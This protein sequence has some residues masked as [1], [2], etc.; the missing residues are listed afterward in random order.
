[1]R[2][3]ATVNHNGKIRGH[4]DWDPKTYKLLRLIAESD[5]RSQLGELTHLIQERARALDITG[6][7][8]EKIGEG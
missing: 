4:Y 1:M 5:Q 6:E 7:V 3:P 8:G 2:R